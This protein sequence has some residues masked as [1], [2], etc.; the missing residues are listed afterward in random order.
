MANERIII[1]KENENETNIPDWARADFKPIVSET[2]APKEEKDKSFD[3]FT[4]LIACG[5]FDD[6]NDEEQQFF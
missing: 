3:E 4:F 2:K 6:P 1:M 5:V